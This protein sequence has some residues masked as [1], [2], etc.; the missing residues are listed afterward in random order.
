MM[1]ISPIELHR[2]FRGL[3]YLHPYDLRLYF[4]LVTCLTYSE[5][6]LYWTTERH[7]PE[8]NSLEFQC[9]CQKSFIFY[10]FRYK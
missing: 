4:L 10:V 1:S 7:I 6:N 5:E 9:V 3:Y 2:R 8:E